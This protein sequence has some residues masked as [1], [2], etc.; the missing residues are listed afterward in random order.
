MLSYFF[1]FALCLSLQTAASVTMP[2]T[3]DE[4]LAILERA[5]GPHQASMIL[6][7]GPFWSQTL[8]MYQI[9]KPFD[10]P[11]LIKTL[12][13]YV[14]NPKKDGRD[15]YP[16]Y[17]AAAALSRCRAAKSLLLL[18]ASKKP[19]AQVVISFEIGSY[20]WRYHDVPS[21]YELFT[22]ALVNY[23]RSKI[24]YVRQQGRRGLTQIRENRRERK[25]GID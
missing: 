16:G 14:L 1:P 10:T 8:I 25:H 4:A 7:N 18:A 5:D 19:A 24:S 17:K 23:R 20:V 2:E 6:R 11:E 3:S 13:W 21:E 12:E 22:D 9:R 15:R